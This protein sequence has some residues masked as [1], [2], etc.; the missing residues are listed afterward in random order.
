MISPLTLLNDYEE[1]EAERLEAYRHQVASIFEDKEDEFDC[2]FE[3]SLNIPK[4][5]EAAVD[6]FRETHFLLSSFGSLERR[7]EGV[8]H[9]G[10]INWCSI[11][12]YI[13]NWHLLS[14]EDQLSLRSLCLSDLKGN[15]NRY[16]VKKLNLESHLLLHIGCDTTNIVNNGRDAVASNLRNPKTRDYS[17]FC[18]EDRTV[19]PRTCR[20]VYSKFHKDHDLGLLFKSGFVCYQAVVVADESYKTLGSSP[21]EAKERIH[22]FFK[23]NSTEFSRLSNKKKKIYSYLYSNEISVD[24]ILSGKYR[25][26]THIIFFLPKAMLVSEQQESVERLEERFNSRFSDRV[27][28]VQRSEYDSRMLPTM[29]DSFEDIANSVNYLFRAYSLSDQYIREARST[30]IRE[31]NK[32]TVECYRNL[33]W[34]FKPTEKGEGIHHSRHSRIPK[35][36]QGDNYIHP[37]LQKNKKRSTMKKTSCIQS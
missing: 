4:P 13:D 1:N 31:L 10:D 8:Q 18:L 23:E 15:A 5:S 16:G 36:G 3:R 32:A 19:D 25:P 37:L 14:K 6:K 22:K 33:I 28:R 12:D 21:E 20:R 34:L 29:V 27:M 24:S 9:K 26:H 30:N 2:R 35:T 7:A 11:D 17:K